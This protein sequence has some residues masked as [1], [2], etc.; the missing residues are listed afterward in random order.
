MFADIG[1]EQSIEQSLSTFSSHM[2]N[3]V[4][5]LDHVDDNSLVLLDELGAGTDPTEGAAL[6]MAILN[7]LYQ[8]H[9]RTLAT[10]HYNELKQ[11]AITHEGI[12][13]ASV[14]FDVKTLSP[15]YRLLIGVPGKSNAFDISRKLGLKEEVIESAKHFV[16]HE[17]IE[18]EEILTQIEENRR[19][20]E[21]EKDEAIR[22]R[23]QVEKLK[24]KLDDKAD[25]LSIQRERVLKEAK[26]EARSLLKD[27]K[28]EAEEIIKDLRNLKSSKDKESNKRIER[29][30]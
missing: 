20:S 18:F 21:E 2:T 14:E 11:Y 12:A 10:T 22:L 9:I 4:D 3:I 30:S 16:E 23:L 29:T 24:N 1:D 17:S 19:T 15:T 13:N 7:K 25:K 5:I 26:E 28:K 8:N 27:A 6:A